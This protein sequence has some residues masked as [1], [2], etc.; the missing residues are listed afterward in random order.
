MLEGGETPIGTGPAPEFDADALP[1][2]TE[3]PAGDAEAPAGDEDPPTGAEEATPGVGEALAGVE[4]ALGVGGERPAPVG[5][6]A[7]GVE[8]APADP[9]LTPLAGPEG[10]SCPP[11]V[12]DVPGA[13]TAVAVIGEA[14]TAVFE[15]A[16]MALVLDGDEMPLAPGAGLARDSPALLAAAGEAPP[17]FDEGDA[18]TAGAVETALGLPFDNTPEVASGLKSTGELLEPWG[19]GPGLE[20]G[21][22]GLAGEL[23]EE[24]GERLEAGLGNTVPG[25]VDA[26]PVP[27]EAAVLR[28][29]G[30]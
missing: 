5:E 2:V 15:D 24:E 11:L 28:L 29:A 10:D 18:A 25:L 3:G 12:N 30:L 6:V 4:E 8:D 22:T 9:G 7:T 20:E 14:A 1:D 17:A 16:D 23:N 19:L 13:A 21:T 27:G 26:A